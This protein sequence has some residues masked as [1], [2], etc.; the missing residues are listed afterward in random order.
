G[1]VVKPWE[2]GTCGCVRCE[3]WQMHEGLDIRCLQR[4]KHGEPTD[5]VMAADDCV[6]AYVNKRPSLSNYGNYL[7]VRH[8]IQGIEIYSLYA[9]LREIRAGLKAGEPVKAGEQIAVMG[10]TANTR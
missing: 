8:R 4:D 5:T 7:V 2:S 6:V 9:H 1:T 3:G 10:R